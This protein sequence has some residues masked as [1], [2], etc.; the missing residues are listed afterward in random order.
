[1]ERVGIGVD[2][3]ALAVMSESMEREVRRLEKEIWE[4]AGVEFN[5]NSPTQLGEILFDKLALAPAVK[6]GRAKQRS[7]AAE[8]LEELSARHPLPRKVIEYREIAK[9][10]STYVD[11]LPKTDSSRN[12]A[13]AHQLLADQR[14]HRP[15]QLLGS[16]SAKYSHSH[17]TGPPDSRRIRRR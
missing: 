12:R 13:P 1:M 3:K 6:R 15:P 2:P 16:Q 10:K 8:I 7:T 17:R 14:R 5:V 9:L 11:A 4:L